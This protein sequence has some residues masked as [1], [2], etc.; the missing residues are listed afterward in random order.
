MILDAITRQEEAFVAEA[1]A[2]KTGF[3]RD[4]VRQV[5]ASRAPRT[6]VALCWKAGL[7]MRTAQQVEIRIARV[8]PKEVVNARDGIDYPL[9]GTEMRQLL[10]LFEA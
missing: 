1:L 10:R 9:T 6:I 7:A 8:P 4:A 2:L 5:L 3:S